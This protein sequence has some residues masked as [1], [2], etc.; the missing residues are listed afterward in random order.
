M[1][2]APARSFPRPSY[3][4]HVP[5]PQLPRSGV[6]TALIA[7]LV[8]TLLG[9]ATWYL[10]RTQPVVTPAAPEARLELLLSGAVTSSLSLGAP[11]LKTVQCSPSEFRLASTP[12]VAFPLEVAFSAPAS[13][14]GTFYVLGSRDNLT[15]NV[16]STAYTL[17]S[18][19]VT[20][21]PGIRTFNA[22]FT[23]A[24]GQPLQL[25]GRL[26]CP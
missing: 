9:T 10:L 2:A 3:Y 23:D 19:T 1:K 15:L 8:L 11:E 13:A 22:S 12:G 18:G 24:Q 4:P 14:N 26:V 17:L 21:T 20:T 25:S 7:A 5:G 16:S 6:E